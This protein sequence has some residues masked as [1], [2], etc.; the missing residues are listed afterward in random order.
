M[1]FCKIGLSPFLDLCFKFNTFRV[2]GREKEKN[3]TVCLGQAQSES[4][5][6]HTQKLLSLME[7]MITVNHLL[8]MN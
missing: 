2:R 7:M 6:S 1:A 3:S 5:V 8:V 4:Y